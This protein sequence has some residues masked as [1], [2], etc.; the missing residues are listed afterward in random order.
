MIRAIRVTVAATA[1]MGSVCAGAVDGRRGLA[2]AQAPAAPQETPASLTFDVT[3][4]KANKSGEPFVRLGG[5]RGQFSA[6]NVPLRLL[7]QNAYRLQPFQLLNAPGW[8]A[9]E[10]FDVLGKYPEG[11]IATP[12]Q[13]S[14][15][16]QALLADRFKLVTHK[17]SREMPVYV[18][19]PSRSDG[20]PGPRIKQSTVDCAAM[21]A[22]R[23]RG[24]GPPPGPPSVPPSGPPPQGQPQP[25]CRVMMGLGNLSSTGMTM[26]Q[27]AQLVAA[28]VGRPVLDK[29]GW[30]GNYEFELEFTPDQMPQGAQPLTLPP[31]APPLPR[32]IRTDRR[33]SRRSRNSSV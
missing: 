14:A 19:M 32:S 25:P 30:N 26:A 10:R 11:M 21:A 28:R 1:V 33:S 6:T 4:V 29:T 2:R 13:T 27:L 15:M 20:T 31:G 12:D 7:I 8:L 9:E 3:S 18:L 24:D 23:G 5:G 17:E 16:L 22:A